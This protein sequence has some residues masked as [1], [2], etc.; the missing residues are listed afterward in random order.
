[1]NTEI[2]KHGTHCVTSRSYSIYID[3]YPTRVF[4]LCMIQT[5]ETGMN[6]LS[7]LNSLLPMHA[8][9]SLEEEGR[10]DLYDFV[11]YCYWIAAQ[12]SQ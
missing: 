8:C 5:F 9:D 7:E 10:N 12:S 2:K 6:F 3:I 11:F 4:L 1:M